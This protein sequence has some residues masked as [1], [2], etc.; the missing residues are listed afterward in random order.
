MKRM[1]ITSTGS[2]GSSG[3]RG[4]IS[5]RL[6][7]RLLVLPCLAAFVLSLYF[8]NIDRF[9]YDAL[10]PDDQGLFQ[11]IAL[12]MAVDGSFSGSTGKEKVFCPVRPP[13]YPV[14][15]ALTRTVSD[16]DWLFL[17]RVLQIAAHVLTIWLMGKIAFII[18]QGSQRFAFLAAAAAAFIP[19]TAALTHVLL[20]ESFTLFLLALSVYLALRA[21]SGR[22]TNRSAIQL[23]ISFGML[24]LM[25]PVFLLLPPLLV[26]YF[27]LRT[28]FRIFSVPTLV[29]FFFFL[30]F[31]MLPWSLVQ[32]VNVQKFTPGFTC[33]GHGLIAGILEGSP[34]LR[35]ELEVIAADPENNSAEKKEATIAFLEQNPDDIR[36]DAQG[37]FD[38][39]TKELITLSFL[40]YADA[41]KVDPPPV[42]SVVLADGY[43]KHASLAWITAHPPGY[44]SV[45]KNNLYTL[46]LGSY[47]PLVYHQLS[48]LPFAF[49]Q[50]ARF[51]LY[52]L[53][54]AGI[55]AAT[56]KGRLQ[57]LGIPLLTIGY[58]LIVHIPMHTEPRYLVEAYPF[59]ALAVPYLL[60]E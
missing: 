53:F 11:R 48:G 34:S 37:Q 42:K 49:S 59:M 55:F 45:M 3:C 12:N 44:L 20:T 24:I 51:V 13:L 7:W 29:L 22:A 9:P 41:W 18:S 38:D 15:L 32:Y 60:T 46:L 30:V 54:L 31:A 8:S 27:F 1:P 40:I 14:C 23:A 36:L 35:K 43:L 21:E 28:R 39:R 52:A 4:K 58:L 10:S 17:V 57:H 26:L 33:I 56:L 6:K 5:P 25:R 2:G 47:Q 19:H 50:Y 16:E